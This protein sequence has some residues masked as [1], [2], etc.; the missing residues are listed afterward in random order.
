M[1]LKIQGLVVRTT[2]YNDTDLLLTLLTADHGKITA[3][4]RGARRKNSRMISCSQ[5][6]AYC[7]YTLF[8]YRGM[9]TVNEAQTVALF[10]QL[11]KDLNK[12]SLATYFAQAAE[13]IAQEDTPTAGLL[14]LLLNSL[15]ALDKNYATDTLIKAVFELRLACISGYEPDLRGCMHCGREVPDRFN[16]FAG[17]LE[18]SKCGN[19]DSHGI[20]MPITP[21]VLDAMRYVCYCEPNKLFSFTLSDQN[22]ERFSELT[23]SYLSAQLERGFSA[24]DFYKSIN[25]Q[26]MDCT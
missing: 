26:T 24:L 2:A 16:V 8:E 12:L 19:S 25:I 18:C 10:P 7:E 20:R 1:Y 17:H 21:G 5:L 11:Q 23:E 14:P 6:L 13:L 15:Y 3:K 4:V 22:V 9:Y